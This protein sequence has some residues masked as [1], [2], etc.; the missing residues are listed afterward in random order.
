MKNLNNDYKIDSRPYLLKNN[1][2]YYQWGATGEDAYIAKLI[3]ETAEPGKPYAELWIGSHPSL[4]SEIVIE[5]KIISLYEVIQKFPKETIGEYVLNRFSKNL[6][7][8]F[9][10]L[11]AAEALSIQAHPNK[12]QAEMLHKSDPEHYPDDNHKPEIAVALDKLVALVGFKPFN[13]IKTVFADYPEMADFIGKEIVTKYVTSNSSDEQVQ[14][15]LTELLYSTLMRLSVSEE[16]RLESA[17]NALENRLSAS[18]AKLKEEEYLFLEQRK[19][20][21]SDVG[22]FS[23]FFLNLVHL[24]AGE[25]IFTD[26]GIPHAYIKG[27]IV[28]CMANSDNVVRAGL[29]PKFKDVETLIN[30]LKYETK[31]A[32]ILGGNPDDEKIVYDIPVTEFRVSRLN[33]KSGKVRIE[34]T[35][36]KPK[37]YLIIEGNIVISWQTETGTQK[38]IYSK[39]QSAFIPAILD[40]FNLKTDNSALL[41][42]IEVP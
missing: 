40:R 15:R 13:E 37:I 30:I 42:K 3:S 28:E 27:N 26:A 36:N 5:D 9:K 16:S 11:S 10:V 32:E 34:S 4:S 12:Q 21:G 18:V 25:A 22:L 23:I 14:S 24:K 39:G 6:P 38:Q 29:T 17:L 8:L 19:K 35:K 1:V 20:Y 2:Q 7:F 31:P 41:F 33:M